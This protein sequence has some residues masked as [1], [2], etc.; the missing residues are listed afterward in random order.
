TG[1]SMTAALAIALLL[2]GG[3]VVGAAVRGRV[4]AT[5]VVAILIGL[6]L[7][8]SLIA[9]RGL[10]DGIGNRTFQPQSG[11]ELQ[12]NYRLGIGHLV[13]DL[14]H[15]SS[16][17]TPVGARLGIGKLVVLV[18]ADAA[19]RVHE[20][21]GMG[22]AEVFGGRQGGVSVDRTNVDPAGGQV[23]FNLDLSVGIGQVEVDR[24]SP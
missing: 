9:P 16:A 1:L 2:T 7:A 10:G 14:T 20:H 18:P 4:G 23:Q 5:P 6:A 3:A 22:N 11:A 13:V 21:V 17:G 15:L 12:R 24:A 8:T 19:V